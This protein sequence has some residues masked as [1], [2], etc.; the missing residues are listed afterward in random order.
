VELCFA[1]EKDKV[2]L[3]TRPFRV[4]FFKISAVSSISTMKVLLSQNR[5][6]FAPTL[7]SRRST[8]CIVCWHEGICLC[9]NGDKSCLPKKNGLSGHIRTSDDMQ[10]RA[11]TKGHCVQRER[12]PGR[13]QANFHGGM[14][15]VDDVKYGARARTCR[16]DR[17]SRGHSR[18][19]ERK[20]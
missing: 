2:V 20:G 12:P 17:R 9:K 5:S 18:E 13:E 3:L 7:E 19:W 6:S 1:L 10:L 16:R 15:I 8:I 4:A 14:A 11:R